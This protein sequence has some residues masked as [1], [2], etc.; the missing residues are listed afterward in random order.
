ME[1]GPQTRAQEQW[2]YFKKKNTNEEGVLDFEQANKEFLAA[3]SKEGTQGYSLKVAVNPATG[4][5]EFLKVNNRTG[6]LDWTGIAVPSDFS[7]DKLMSKNPDGYGPDLLDGRKI[8]FYHENREIDEKMLKWL[9]EELPD[10]ID[11]V[12]G[13]VENPEKARLRQYIENLPKTPEPPE[14]ADVNTIKQFAVAKDMSFEEARVELERL[15][16]EVREPGA[17]GAFRRRGG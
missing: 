1:R 3:T 10:T 12:D 7:M 8:R 14:A 5:S 9:V 15:G 13:I 6:D 16:L 11:T 2:N 17:L 4:L